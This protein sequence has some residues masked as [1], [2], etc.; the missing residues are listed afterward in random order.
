MNISRNQTPSSQSKT[1][2]TRKYQILKMFSL[3]K[4]DVKSD[5]SKGK[6]FIALHVAP[7]MIFPS[8]SEI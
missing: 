1:K 7:V 2:E 5:V 3:R 8:G 6:A 4:P